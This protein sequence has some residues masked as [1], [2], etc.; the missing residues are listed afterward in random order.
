M[1]WFNKDKTEKELPILEEA[2]LSLL[3]KVEDELRFSERLVETY[4]KAVQEDQGSLDRY[5]QSV[6]LLQEKRQKLIEAANEAHS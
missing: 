1:S 3:E 5:T 2:R 6:I 4:K